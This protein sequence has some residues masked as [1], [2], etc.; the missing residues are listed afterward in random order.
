MFK[1][2]IF[3]EPGPVPQPFPVTIITS[4]SAILQWNSTSDP[5][6]NNL[7]YTAIVTP[8]D[9]VNSSLSSRRR[10]QT[11]NIGAEVMRCLAFLKLNATIIVNTNGTVT[12]TNVTGLSKLRYE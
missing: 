11:N 3:V 9:I 1:L 7:S 12:I 8:I 4:T 6:G 10:R 2:Y 5:N